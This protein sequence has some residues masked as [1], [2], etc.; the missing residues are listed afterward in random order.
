MSIEIVYTDDDRPYPGSVILGGPSSADWRRDA[1]YYLTMPGY[2]L[3]RV[4]AWIGCVRCKG[5]GSWRVRPKGWR[6]RTPPPA[7]ACKLVTCPVCKGEGA[8]G[9][10]RLDHEAITAADYRPA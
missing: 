8:I 3:I 2:R 10:I 9:A 5:I 4:I 1:A 7:W 6:K